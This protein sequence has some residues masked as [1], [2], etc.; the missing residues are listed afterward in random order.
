MLAVLRFREIVTINYN[1]QKGIIIKNWG[2]R[3][4]LHGLIPTQALLN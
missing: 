2:L 3:A 4:E 1:R